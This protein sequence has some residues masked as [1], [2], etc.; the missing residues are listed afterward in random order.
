MVLEAFRRWGTD[1]L[2]RLRG[3]FA[4]G[5]FDER[6]GELTLVRDQLG[7]K[8]LFVHRRGAAAVFSSE[9]KALASEVDGLTVDDGALVA[10]LLYYWVPDQRCAFREAEKLRPGSWLRLRPDGSEQRGVYWDIR[11]VANEAQH[12]PPLDRAAG[13]HDGVARARQH[14][15]VGIGPPRAFLQV[16]GEAVV[17]AEEAGL[18]RLFQAQEWQELWVNYFCPG[19]LS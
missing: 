19:T 14:R 3:M 15:R 18:L 2:P 17:Q 1:C 16:A 11:Q 7:I 10:S 9:L 6:T 13:P 12:L 5:I 8:P 4:F